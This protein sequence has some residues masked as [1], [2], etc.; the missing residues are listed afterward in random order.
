MINRFSKDTQEIVKAAR[1]IAEEQGCTYISSTH[2]FMAIL[3]HRENY[4]VQ[5]I[6][7]MGYNPDELLEGF[8]VLINEKPF[9]KTSEQTEYIFTTEIKQILE[10]A[11]QEMHKTKW[12]NIDSFHILLGLLKNKQSEV[13]Q[14]LEKTDINYNKTSFH[15]NQLIKDLKST[16]NK[17]ATDTT[18]KVKTVHRKKANTPALD[19]FARNLTQAARE[20]KIDPVIGRENEVKRMWQI[21]ARRKKNNIIVSGGSG[22]GKSCL[23]EG[24]AL[25]IASQNVPNKLKD[26][27]IHLLDVAGMIAGSKYRGEFEKKLKAVIAEC[28]EQKNIIL[29][30]D[31]IHTLIGSGNSEGAMDGANML[32][33]ALSNGELQVIGATTTEEYQK[34][35][36]KDAALVRRF[37]KLYI[38]A[39]SKEDTFQILK[40]IRK[41]Y[42]NFHKVSYSDDI[43]KLIVDL[44]EK[45][46]NTSHEPD[47][48]INTLDE[49][50]SKL[51]LVDSA[52][53][54]ELKVKQAELHEIENDIKK[55]V[56]NKEYEKAA[57]VKPLKDAKVLEIK[58]LENKSMVQTTEVTEKDVREVFSLI[59]GVPVESIESNTDASKK[60]LNMAN[61][62]REKIVNQD[63]AI[64][65]VSKI[66]K[67]KKAGVE[68]SKKPSVILLAG[69]TGTGKTYL[70]KKLT[71]FLFGDEKKMVFL[72][73]AEYADKTAV[74]R[75]TSSNPGYVGYGEATDFEFIRN[76]PYSVLLVDECEKMHHEIWQIFLRIFE[77]GELKTANGKLISFK[78]CV[79]LLT[80]NLGSEISKRAAVGFD[81]N[82]EQEGNKD[83]KLKYETAIKNYFKPEVFNRLSKV[84]VFND[85]NMDNLRQ[86]V[87]LEL[88][89][90][91]AALKEKNIKLVVNE[92]V[93]DFIINTSDDKA[94]SMGARPIKRSIEQ[95]LN[96]PLADIILE[97][98]NSIK[99]VTI[100]L[101]K[102]QLTFTTK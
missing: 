45:Y 86:I 52:V 9:K 81:L 31:E 84:V 4:A 63:E 85:L 96:D 74:N 27:E 8:N 68:N 100:S 24:L 80:S 6:E 95:L 48:S 67:R 70:A 50:G 40:G 20:G 77:E 90:L 75:L 2:F 92:N 28:A 46:I 19:A 82:N 72:N 11:E 38:E 47:K 1:D 83:R 62:L 29:F 79:I 53:S 51:S 32:K 18:E 58:E 42:E 102:N 25:R 49:V 30:I 93:H 12:D 5:V 3:A 97:K 91:E 16:S 98:G 14:I 54:K 26:K 99:T 33:P 94:K 41:H 59:S 13:N 73:G 65:A 15:I 17:T 69:A 7:R 71:E 21:L 87:K 34:Y 56:R 61:I 60:Y 64:D 89:P 22:V 101:K 76:N 39:P 78:N 43:L 88:K 57:T 35:F 55:L 10:V 44:S 23:V 66:I 36:E 37:Q